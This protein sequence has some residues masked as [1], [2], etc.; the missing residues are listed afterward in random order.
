MKENLINLYNALMTVETKGASTK[1]LA[2][3]L[4]FLEQLVQQCDKEETK[5][6]E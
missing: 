2:N 6:A 4:Q 1:T 5:A 3:C